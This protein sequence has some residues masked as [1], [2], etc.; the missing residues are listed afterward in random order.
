[1]KISLTLAVVGF[2]YLLYL[3]SPVPAKM[4]V[5]G[6]PIDDVELM[7]LDQNRTRLSTLI[8]RP[9]ILMIWSMG[10]PICV[11][12]LK[13][14]ERLSVQ[15]RQAGYNLF[16]INLDGPA[17]IQ[18][19]KTLLDAKGIKNLL[20]FAAIEEIGVSS[21]PTFLIVDKDLI[22]R[23][24]FVGSQTPSVLKGAVFNVLN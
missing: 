7:G 6:K 19:I 4:P 3:S 18:S 16:T 1:M 15:L 13:E 5:V 21:F 24:I 12:E 9:S 2:L 10:C 22:V 23:N 11:G 17:S 20:V 8:K 14:M